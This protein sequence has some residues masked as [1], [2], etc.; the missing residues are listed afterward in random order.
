MRSCLRMCLLGSNSLAICGAIFD[1]LR[2]AKNEV[3]KIALN[4]KGSERMSQDIDMSYRVL[5]SK[6]PLGV[7]GK[8]VLKYLFTA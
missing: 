3:R 5:K 2:N 8:W 4:N 6:T 1:I 7:G